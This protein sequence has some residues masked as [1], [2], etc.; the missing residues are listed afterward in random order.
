MV[1]DSDDLVRRLG[2]LR[3]LISQQREPSNAVPCC[4]VPGLAF[5]LICA[6]AIGG[7]PG[8]PLGLIVLVTVTVV[9]VALTLDFLR[10]NS[11]IRADHRHEADSLAAQLGLSV[12]KNKWDR[13]FAVP[14]DAA[15]LALLAEH[16]YPRGSPLIRCRHCGKYIEPGD[17][18]GTCVACTQTYHIDCMAGEKCLHCAPQSPARA[19][20]EALADEDLDERLTLDAAYI[21]EH[22]VEHGIALEPPPVDEQL[23]IDDADRIDIDEFR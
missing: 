19:W 9:A 3:Q 15:T 6:L 18:V 20:T 7:P 23:V 12:V 2:E 21:R 14:R 22:Y 8:P 10:R 1:S 5:L 13:R 16:A 4:V 17:L 11:R